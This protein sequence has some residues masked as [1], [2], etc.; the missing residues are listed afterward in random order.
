MVRWAA[1][2]QVAGCSQV[3]G[4]R[5]SG[6]RRPGCR[7]P[8][9]RGLPW[10]SPAP[11]DLPSEVP[12]PARGVAPRGRTAGP[13]AGKARSGPPPPTLNLLGSS[14]RALGR[15]GVCTSQ[16]RDKAGTWLGAAVASP[17]GLRADA[18]GDCGSSR[19]RGRPDACT[20]DP[21]VCSQAALRRL[22]AASP[23][24]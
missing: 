22:P 21:V 11:W 20:G 1:T 23:H 2:L 16:G 13:A 8:S 24:A 18:A 3:S 12:H 19:V 7:Q 6:P 15:A 17:E 10:Q 5:R 4:P 14:P 9:F